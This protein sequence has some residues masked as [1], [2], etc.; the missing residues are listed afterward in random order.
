MSAVFLSTGQF[1]PFNPILGETK[2]LIMGDM[3]IDLE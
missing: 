1:K 3:N 2:Q